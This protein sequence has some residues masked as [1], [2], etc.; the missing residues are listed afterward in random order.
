MFPLH[1]SLVARVIPDKKGEGTLGPK[2]SSKILFFRYCKTFTFFIQQLF[3][4][5]TILDIP[6]ETD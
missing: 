5:S 2:H 6:S 1:Q 3:Y 4:S